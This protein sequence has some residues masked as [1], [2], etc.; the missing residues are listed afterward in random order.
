[1]A[2]SRRM[3]SSESRPWWMCYKCTDILLFRK[4]L[5]LRFYTIIFVTFIMMILMFIQ[6]YMNQIFHAVFKG[7]Y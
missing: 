3:S 4:Q 1:M 2:S 7:I 5:S 6:T